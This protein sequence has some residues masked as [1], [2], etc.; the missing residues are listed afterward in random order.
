ML[1][2]KNPYSRPGITLKKV[3]YVVI[4]YVGNPGSTAVANRNYFEGLKDSKATYASSH[5][6]VGLDGEIIQCVPENEIAY[7]SNERNVDSISIETC[8]P[9]SDGKFNEKTYKTLTE[10]TADICKRYNLDIEKAVIR[11]YD[12]TG[13]KCPLYYVNNPNE[14]VI[15]KQDVKKKAMTDSGNEQEENKIKIKINNETIEIEGENINGRHSATLAEIAKLFPEDEEF[16]IRNV[17]N[18]CNYTVGWL[19]EEGII[20]VS[21]KS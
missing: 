20:T 17:L 7:T 15:L 10:L 21:N 13:K 14:W 8:H 2:T 6:I 3:N 1:L 9:K 18:A 19:P 4:H 12:V 5:Y 16:P 11:H